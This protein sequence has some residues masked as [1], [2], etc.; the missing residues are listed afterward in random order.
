M[1]IRR[2][3]VALAPAFAGIGATGLFTNC[4]QLVFPHDPMRFGIARATGGFDADP[5]R[6]LWL[7]LVGAMGLFW[8]A[9]AGDFQI[10]HGAGSF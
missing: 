5:R 4:D 10:A 3:G 7:G 6:L 1:L 2:G 9:F 8:V